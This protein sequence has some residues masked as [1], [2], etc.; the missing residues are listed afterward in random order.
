MATFLAHLRKFWWI[1]E[2]KILATL[3]P[4]LFYT[5]SM[6]LH[7]HRSTSKS[8]FKND[9]CSKIILM[10]FSTFSSHAIFC[11]ELG[12]SGVTK[13]LTAVIYDFS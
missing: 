7:W 4:A 9:I 5:S 6:H 1:S 3:H 13:L 11:R 2:K 10:F 12:P 8:T